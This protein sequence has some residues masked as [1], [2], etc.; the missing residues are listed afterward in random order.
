M[1]RVICVLSDLPPSTAGTLPETRLARWCRAVVVVLGVLLI[2]SLTTTVRAQGTLPGESSNVTEN[3]IQ[4]EGRPFGVAENAPPT[5]T[6]PSTLDD[7]LAQEDGV[8]SPVSTLS[9]E[10]RAEV[11]KLFE[12]FRA[13]EDKKKKDAEDLKKKQASEAGHEVGSDLNLNANWNNGLWFTTAKKDWNI[14]FGGRFEFQSSFFNQPTSM[15][16]PPPGNGGI[17]ASGPNGGVGTLQDGAFFRRVRLRSD[18]VG[19]EQIEYVMEVDFEQI[20]L[21]AFDHVWVG[22]KE[23]PLLGTVRVGQ[24]KVPQGLE[25][26][27]SDY[28]LTF[29]ERSSLSDAFWTLFAPGVFLANTFMDDNVTFQTMFH[30]I[31]PNGYFVNDFGTGD[32]ASTSR[33]TW[34]PYYAEEGRHLIHFGGS[35]QWRR[36]D[37]GS[38]ILPG[39]TGNATADNERVVRFRARPEIRD[40]TGVEFPYGNTSRYV[41]T[42]FLVADSVQ[43]ISPEFL[44]IGG[45]LSVQAEGALSIVDNARTIY[46]PTPG[47]S[48]GSPMFWGGYA[49]TSYV[50]T[51]ENRGYDRRFG[52]FDRIK[53]RE[54]FFATRNQSGCLQWA[55]GAWEVGYRYSHID[56][57]DR[58]LDGGLLGQHTLGL[59]WYLNDNVKMQ[60]NYNRAQRTVAAPAV[61]GGVDSFGVLVKWYF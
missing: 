15:Q 10:Q 16:G 46:G 29:L 39:G 3:E 19:Y 55:P 40:G 21:I 54:N 30:R 24:H 50:L 56:L 35:Y 18:G 59:N 32:Y 1:A 6:L 44:W 25:M 13:A 5:E 26:M 58:G 7:V 36:A 52:M 57:N 22:A 4:A 14:H 12:S 51:G 37:L 9:K 33:V 27:G 20:N 53:V 23:I 45:P 47:A 61:T 34:T 11:Q 38:S 17:P 60:F 43:T 28:H 49:Q 48:L 41:D 8:D 2:L 31:Q 42:G